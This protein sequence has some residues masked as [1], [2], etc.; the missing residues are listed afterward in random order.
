[1]IHFFEVM[2][3]ILGKT[4]DEEYREKKKIIYSSNEL[5]EEEKA[6][7]SLNLFEKLQQQLK[8]TKKGSRIWNLSN[9]CIY[10]IDA[11]ERMARTSKMNMIMHG[12]GHGGIHYHDGFL[13]VNGIFD[14]RFDIVLTNPPFGQKVEEEDI[15][16]ESQVELDEEI[17]KYYQKIDGDF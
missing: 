15:V 11:N 13:N 17:Q 7:K 8:T 2:K 9:R 5:T 4:V 14:G 10:G 12:D 6:A 3:N 1:M 16:L